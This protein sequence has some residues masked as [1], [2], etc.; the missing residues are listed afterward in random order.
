MF[1]LI[2][3]N[4]KKDE[5]NEPNQMLLTEFRDQFS[6]PESKRIKGF[7]NFEKNR[8]GRMAYKPE[9]DSKGVEGICKY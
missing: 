9:K 4:K 6:N 8:R 2:F 5:Q 1:K 7:E 3:F